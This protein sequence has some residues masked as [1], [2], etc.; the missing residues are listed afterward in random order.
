MSDTEYSPASGTLA[1]RVCNW[2][3]MSRNR[4]EER[5]ATELAAQFEV[6][7]P[8]LV[9][10]LGDAI[11]AKLIVWEQGEAGYVY[12]AGPALDA[13]VRGETAPADAAK[14]KKRTG[15]GGARKRLPP[16]DLSK[17]EVKA[18]VP[19]PG[20]VDQPGNRW[21]PLLQKLDAP[22]KSVTLPVPYRGSF[23]KAA[24]DWA[25]A[26]NVKFKTRAVSD[27][28]FGCWRVA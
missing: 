1:W 27:T 16:L 15:S 2:Y 22:G 21:L 10:D 5:N 19:L 6:K 11:K 28:E 25:K 9:T 4:T 23:S 12:K 26:N 13:W 18:D 17:I 20:G 24:N 3:G 7:R 14:P 8:Q